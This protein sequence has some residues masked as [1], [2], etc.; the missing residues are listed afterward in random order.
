VVKAFEIRSLSVFPLNWL[1]RILAPTLIAPTV[2]KN[3]VGKRPAKLT[4]AISVSPSRPTMIWSTTLKDEAK[5]DW[6][7]TG[8]AIFR[9]CD[10]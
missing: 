4:E 1:I 5:S 6:S 9:I 8:I 3:T 10:K 7:E 2:K